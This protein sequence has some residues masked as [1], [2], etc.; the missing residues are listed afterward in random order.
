MKHIRLVAAAV[1]LLAGIAY[2]DDGAMI[3][4]RRCA[5]CHGAK[6]EGKP[7]VKAPALKGTSLDANQIVSHLMNGEPNSKPP[8]NKGLSGLKPDDAKAVAE[9]VKSLK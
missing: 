7:G 5:G 1:V 6:G 4:S 2:A 8:H 3:F 9:Y